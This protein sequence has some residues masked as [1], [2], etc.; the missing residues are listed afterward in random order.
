MSAKLS[1]VI[2]AGGAGRRFSGKTKPKIVIGGEPIIA[3][4]LSVIKDLFRE[5]IIVTNNPEE[6]KDFSFCMI[7]KDEIQGAGPLGGIH[8]AM[9]ASSN[10]AVFV[11]AGDMPF[12]D[13][14]T[15]VNM[16]EAYFSSDCDAL[17][18]GIG[19][20]IEP[21]HSI[22]NTSLADDLEAYLEHNKSKAV[23]EYIKTLNVDYLLL[24][25]SERNQRAFTNVN[26]PADIFPEDWSEKSSPLS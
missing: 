10:E 14:E 4:I 20:L 6:F 1:G 11:F 19:D 24:E 26:S 8:A 9:K 23:R 5:I 2:L 12:L 21:L 3:R 25:A 16:T 13:I 18:P 22:Y 7:V 17:I 15:I